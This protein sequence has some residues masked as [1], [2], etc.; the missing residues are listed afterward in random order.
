[1]VRAYHPWPGARCRVRRSSGDT[2]LTLR[3]VETVPGEVAAP[4]K[5]AVP[6]RRTLLV[7]CGDVALKLLELTP[8]SSKT[9]DAAAYLNGLRGEKIEFLLRGE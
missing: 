5:V 2:V 7:G 8:E 6:D 9:M 4:G 3:R 1:M